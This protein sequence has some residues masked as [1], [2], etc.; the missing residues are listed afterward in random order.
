MVPTFNEWLEHRDP[1]LHEGWKQML[2][3][4]LLGAASVLPSIGCKDGKCTT[5]QQPTAAVSSVQNKTIPNKSVTADNAG[6]YLG[7]EDERAKFLPSGGDTGGATK[8]SQGVYEVQ[9]STRIP[10]SLGKAKGMEVAHQR[11]TNDAKMKLMKQLG[12]NDANMS[13]EVLSQGADGSGNYVVKL[14]ITLR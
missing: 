11:A 7:G 1:E 3:T 10:K 12:V 13:A 8:V 6:D 4:G 14:K 2:A 5:P 9:G